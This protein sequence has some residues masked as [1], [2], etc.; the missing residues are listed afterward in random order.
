MWLCEVASSISYLSE[1]VE[2]NHISGLGSDR[3]GSE[4]ELVVRSNRDHHCGGGDSHG[5]GKSDSE[6]GGEKHLVGLLFVCLLLF[7]VE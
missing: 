4:L 7:A 6:D 5:L 3:V 1:E 2:S